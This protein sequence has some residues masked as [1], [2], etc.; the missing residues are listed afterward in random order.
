MILYN[1]I[2]LVFIYCRQV[3]TTADLYQLLQSLMYVI[4]GFSVSAV[5]VW[6]QDSWVLAVSTTRLY[7]QLYEDICCLNLQENIPNH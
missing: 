2:V 3:L 5:P 6:I 7:C 4:L 1:K